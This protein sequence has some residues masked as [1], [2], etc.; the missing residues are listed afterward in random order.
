MKYS[1]GIA[2]YNEAA[3]IGRL[4]DR[5][6]L[7]P[8]NGSGLSEIIVVASGCTDGTNEIVRNYLERDRRVKLINEA[9]R[10]GKAAAVN[11]FISSSSSDILVLMSADILP[12]D[13]ALSCLIEPFAEKTVG[14]TSGRIIPGNDRRSFM[15][16]YVNLFWSLHHRIASQSFKAGEVVAFRRVIE[17]IPDDTATDETWIV[18]QVVERG[19]FP[20]YVPGAVFRNRG[21]DNIKDFLKVR[22]R[23]IIGYHHMLK[24]RPDWNLPDTM[25]NMVVLSLLKD[26]IPADMKN[27]VYLIGSMLL[28]ILARVLAWY[29]FYLAKRN[30]FIWETA[31]STKSPE[32]QK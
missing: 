11:L 30:P 5:L 26:E 8:D 32:G 1:V 9:R 19:Y 28:E 3:N 12:D 29:D 13:G 27:L 17:G 2:A 22:R 25:N 24:L 7:Y 15:G 16:F 21:P 6:L 10:H 4:L 20:K 18:H 14:V 23:H 31:D